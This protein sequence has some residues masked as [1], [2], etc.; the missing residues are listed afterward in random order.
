MSTPGAQSKSTNAFLVQA[1][2]AFAISFSAMGIGI[3]RLPLDFWQRGFLV[4]SMLF[5]V[6]SC[7]TLAKVIRD[8]HEQSKV[9]HRIDEAR[10]EKLIAEHDPF[11]VVS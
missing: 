11:K 6:S 10:L 8:Q 3:V 4:M 7:F 9:H 1:A 5:L 2:I